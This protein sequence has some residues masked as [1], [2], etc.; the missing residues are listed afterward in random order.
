MAVTN[1]TTYYT[2]DLQSWGEEHYDAM[3][4]SGAVFPQCHTSTLAQCLGSLSDQQVCQDLEGGLFYG[5]KS[6]R[7]PQ[8]VCHTTYLI[9]A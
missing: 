5:A 2:T 9:K 3:G 1:Y 4:S 7:V 8:N 6:D